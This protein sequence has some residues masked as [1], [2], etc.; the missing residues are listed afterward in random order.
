MLLTNNK[1]SVFA[2]GVWHAALFQLSSNENN[3]ASFGPNEYK[4]EKRTF[5]HRIELREQ[6]SHRSHINHTKFEKGKEHYYIYIYI[7]S[8]TVSCR[9]CLTFEYI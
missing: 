2:N 3:T 5:L 4:C 7:C 9:S 1:E 6:K 8:L